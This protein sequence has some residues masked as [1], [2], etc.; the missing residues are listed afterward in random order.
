METP[1]PG[2]RRDQ[3]SDSISVAELI[4]RSP[5]I[6]DHER[7]A[8]ELLKDDDTAGTQP[9][10][11]RIAFGTLGVLLLL[12]AASSTTTIVS[13]P[14]DA[15]RPTASAAP[16]EGGLALRPDLVRDARWPFA[17]NAG[18]ADSESDGDAAEQP[19]APQLM[20]ANPAAGSAESALTVVRDFYQHLPQDTTGALS[21]VS[22]DLV[23]GQQTSLSRAWREAESVQAK[24][25]SEPD[26]AVRADVEVQYPDG[27]RVVLHQRLT[28]EP[29]PAP[30]IDG[31]ELLGAKHSASH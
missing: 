4:R 26:G 14:A 19:E 17:A 12:G 2:R 28:V 7:L 27:D 1:S 25:W 10:T 9:L 3:T 23:A 6:A 20:T 15:P 31:V 21:M 11:G 29:D 5:F 16:I 24:P 30:K 8:D 18:F 13:K 22:P